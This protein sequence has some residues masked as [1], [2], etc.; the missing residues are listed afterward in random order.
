MLLTYLITYLPDNGAGGQNKSI[1][2]QGRLSFQPCNDHAFGLA[3]EPRISLEPLK[4]MVYVG[5][6]QRGRSETRAGNEKCRS[7]Q[8]LL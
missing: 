2:V 3:L 1:N 5:R 4:I 7:Q 8:Q 6:A